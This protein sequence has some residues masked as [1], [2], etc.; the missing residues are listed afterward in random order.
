MALS[1]PFRVLLLCG[2]CTASSK[3]V[4][5]RHQKC[6]GWEAGALIPWPS[7]LFPRLWSQPMSAFGKAAS[8]YLD[9]A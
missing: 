7:V 4:G 3:R 2:L 6:L 8:F 5:C 1:D 9:N